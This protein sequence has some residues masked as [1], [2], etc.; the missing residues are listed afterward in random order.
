M[1]THFDFLLAKVHKFMQTTKQNDKFYY[2]TYR[3]ATFI[4]VL[5]YKLTNPNTD[6]PN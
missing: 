5:T 1:S 2:K 4:T 6:I 3:F